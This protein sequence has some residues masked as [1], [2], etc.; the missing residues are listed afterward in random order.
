MH[1]IVHCSYS[2]ISPSLII[3]LHIALIR[4]TSLARFRSRPFP[5]IRWL[6]T[7]TLGTKSYLSFLLH[8][9]A[10][11]LSFVVRE[12]ILT[13][14]D[15]VPYF[16]LTL[17]VRT[18]AVFVSDTSSVKSVPTSKDSSMRWFVCCDKLFTGAAH[19]VLEI[20]H[21]TFRTIS[22]VHLG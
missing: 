7:H 20:L 17:R 14:V 13:V 1:L 16:P 8:N 2:G 15:A 21:L 11:L 5:S 6:A 3:H 10:L 22:L 12:A 18:S 19:K 9:A 4:S